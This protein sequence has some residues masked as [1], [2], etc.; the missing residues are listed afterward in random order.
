M[1]ANLRAANKVHAA[2]KAGARTQKEIRR[3]TK[4]LQDD[5]CDALAYLILTV[6]TIRTETDGYTRQYLPAERREVETN[7]SPLS[8]STIRALMPTSRS[9]FRC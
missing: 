9:P 3:M 1:I 6:R 7:E 5:V 8:F 4:L 2:V